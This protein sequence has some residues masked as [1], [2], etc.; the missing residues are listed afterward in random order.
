MMERYLLI[1]RIT[2]MRKV[3]I[4]PDCHIDTELPPAYKVAKKFIK[5][6]KPDEIILL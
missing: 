5:D 1:G 2:K 4:L 6:E 3:I